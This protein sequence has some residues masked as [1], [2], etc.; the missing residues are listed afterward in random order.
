MSNLISP[1]DLHH[2]AEE[3]SQ[4]SSD[5]LEIAKRLDNVTGSLE[6]KWAG[7]AKQAFF[8]QYKEWRQVSAGF[9]VLLSNIAKELDGMAEHYEQVDKNF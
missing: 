4:A 5:T 8:Q 1:Q 2:A 3:F 6:K 7:A 9:A